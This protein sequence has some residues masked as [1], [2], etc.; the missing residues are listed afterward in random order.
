M[1]LLHLCRAEVT[2]AWGNGRA[3]VFSAFPVV[4]RSM[5]LSVMTR[6][7]GLHRHRAGLRKAGWYFWSPSPDW[8][9]II[10]FLNYLKKK[11]SIWKF[12]AMKLN[13]KNEKVSFLF[14][15]WLQCTF[16]SACLSVRI[17]QRKVYY[18]LP[19]TVYRGCLNSYERAFGG[20][21]SSVYVIGS[22]AVAKTYFYLLLVGGEDFIFPFKTC[23]YITLSE[24][25]RQCHK[26]KSSVHLSVG[27][28]KQCPVPKGPLLLDF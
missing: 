17:M 24:G 8:G 18:L 28:P 16:I 4:N 15:S 6:D 21:W 5:I 7:P 2:K 9:G 1:Q 23:L 11:N 19:T 10:Y 14:H 3:K 13:W 25:A 12:S 22:I 20:A 27:P 26:H